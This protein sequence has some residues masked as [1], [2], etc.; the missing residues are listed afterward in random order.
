M[1]LEPVQVSN[2]LRLLYILF[3]YNARLGYFVFDHDEPIN[4][5]IDYLNCVLWIMPGSTFVQDS[6][7][8]Y[9]VF[10]R[11]PFPRGDFVDPPPVSFESDELRYGC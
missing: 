1:P 11:V 7:I 4:G 3:R 8:H 6:E 9:T 5:I 2:D 10:V